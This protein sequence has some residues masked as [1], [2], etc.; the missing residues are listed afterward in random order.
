MSASS[1]QVDPSNLDQRGVVR[2][3]T[4]LWV[5]VVGRDN[6]PV[7]RAGNICASGFF[8]E[9]EGWP[10]RPG[11]IA[12]IPCGFALAVPPGYEAQIRPRSGLAVKHGLSIPNAPGTI[13][14]DY[15]GEV[16]VALI[17]HGG[18]PVTVTEEIPMDI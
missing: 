10:G 14:S 2:I 5:R 1:R 11:D 12:V 3:E 4:E 7:R 15:R 16:K 17:N 8:F 6:E 13:D 9:A 18:Q